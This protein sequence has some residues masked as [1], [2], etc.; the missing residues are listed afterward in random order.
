[1]NLLRL[2]EPSVRPTGSPAP[3]V[4]PRSAVEGRSFEDLL[5]E[6]GR[7]P[8]PDAVAIAPEARSELDRMGIRLSDQQMRAVG[9]AIDRADARGSRQSLLMMD[10]AAL[11]VDVAGRTITDA[12]NRADGG[13]IMP[14]D[15]AVFVSELPEATFNR[16]EL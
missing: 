2:L 10:E 7:S 14:I 1:M 16:L 5:R 12:M 9:E 8:M 4:Q 15:S 6:A 13:V 3:R 11:R